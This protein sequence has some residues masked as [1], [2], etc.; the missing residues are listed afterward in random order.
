MDYSSFDSLGIPN[1][2]ISPKGKFSIGR[3][4]V[5]INDAKSAV[6]GKNNRCKIVVG[7]GAS[8]IIGDKIGISN[9]TI[10]STKSIVF[11]NNILVGGGATIVDT[12][13]HSLDS[14]DWHS[15]NDSKNMKSSPVVIKDNV[16]IGMNSIILKGVT[17]G[18]NVIVAA[19]SVV[20]KNIPDNQVWGGNPAKFIKMR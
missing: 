17:V 4:F 13:F 5:M 19:G 9:V 14:E 6:L 16:F 18:S 12:D 11:G 10:V 2:E 20:T 1:L 7:E 8:L 15:A 3:M